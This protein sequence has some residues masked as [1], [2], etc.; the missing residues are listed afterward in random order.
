MCQLITFSGLPGVGKTTIAKAL[1]REMRAT[2]IR[3]DVIES[4]LRESTLEAY[5]CGNAGYLA[6]AGLAKSNLLTGQTVVTDMVNPNRWSR[7]LWSSVAMHCQVKALN[8]EVVCSNEKIHRERVENRQPDIEGHPLPS[9]ESVKGRAY[10]PRDDIDLQ[11]DS[12]ALNVAQSVE[13][14]RRHVD[15]QRG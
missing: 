13:M 7:E 4:A 5:P 8:I 3:I 14:V 10:D 11:L 2:Y 15:R 12:A 1:C 9:W 6:A